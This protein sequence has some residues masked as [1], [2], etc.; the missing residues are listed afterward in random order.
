MARTFFYRLRDYYL[1]V[2]EV[3]RGEADAASVFPNKPDIG[4]ARERVYADFLRQHAPSK[5][6]VFLG[7]FL[8]DDDGVESKQLDVIVTTDTTPRFDL[9]NPEGAGK[10]FSPVEGTLAV[11]SIK[12]RLDKNA[13]EDALSNIASIPAMKSLEGRVN[14]MIKVRG[15]DDWPYKIVYATDGLDGETVLRHANSFY[16]QRADIPITRRPHM[17]HV[18]GKYVIM[19]AVPGM[20]LVST[21]GGPKE[22]PQLGTYLLIVRDAD[23]HG[24]VWA[25]DNLQQNASAS[26]HIIFSYGNL[27]NKVSLI[28]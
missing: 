17:I 16:D 23:L 12:S 20:E 15:Y 1:R 19:R 28:L 5:C 4:A 2:A 22:T 11:A 21:T 24:I 13:L 3:L 10:S 9:L 26:T 6:N 27:I 18:A 14:I 25:L 7:G 8:F